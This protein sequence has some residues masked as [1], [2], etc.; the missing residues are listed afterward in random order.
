MSRSSEQNHVSM[1]NYEDPNL[2]NREN[3]AFRSGD[4]A[5]RVQ[6]MIL[7]RGDTG[8]Q[9]SSGVNVPTFST[10]NQ[11]GPQSTNTLGVGQASDASLGADNPNVGYAG[12][13]PAAGQTAAGQTAGQCAAPEVPTSRDGRSGGAAPGPSLIEKYRQSST[14]PPTTGYGA[15]QDSGY[16]GQPSQQ[17]QGRSRGQGGQNEHG[18]GDYE[19]VADLLD[20]MWP[21][22][23]AAVSKEAEAQL[24]ALIK[25]SKPTWM[26]DI[27]IHKMELGGTPPR[28]TDIRVIKDEG[29]K[30]LTGDDYIYLEMDFTWNSKQDVEID[31]SPVPDKVSFL[32]AFVSKAVS[33]ATCFQ[34]GVE[35]FQMSGNIMVSFRPLMNQIPVVGAIQVSFTEAPDFDFDV[36]VGEGDTKIL[37]MFPA[38]KGFL[39]GFIADTL[40]GPY[41]TPDHYFYAMDPMAPDI[42]IPVGYIEV[43]VIEAKNVPKMDLIGATDAYVQI[44]THT[45]GV[46]KTEIVTG[47]NPTWN[48][49]YKM[50]IM[51]PRYQQLQLIMWDSD[52]GGDDEVGRAK[53]AVSDLQTNK[54]E[55]MWLPIKPLMSQDKSSEKEQRDGQKKSKGSRF[56]K[57]LSKPIGPP[58]P[59][60]KH[61]AIHVRLTYRE[62]SEQQI[63][64]VLEA[65][66]NKTLI[67][68]PFLNELLKEEKPTGTV[69]GDHAQQAN[70]V[71]TS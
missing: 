48:A 60:S 49:S 46:Q 24:P 44:M 39:Y 12:F 2:Q 18:N 10:V 34:C 58:D 69:A 11:A 43:E 47:K 62:L 8:L 55:D 30:G 54:T 65:E 13:P 22:I 32:P 7:G 53:Y 4:P 25:S 50:P 71:P 40:L 26:G 33:K 37:E 31:V 5:S 56:R 38:L 42:Q 29:N 70:A 9:S 15:P 61:T 17:L 64:I 52:T 35:N 27:D 14:Q 6:E 41:I 20:K 67:Q 63:R 19:W 45:R 68:D 16:R 3:Q 66:Q 36:T 23:T 57:A 51:V 59:E 28:L 21:Y 1:S